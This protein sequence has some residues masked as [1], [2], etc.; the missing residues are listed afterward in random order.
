PPREGAAPRPR[1]PRPPR[2]GGEARRRAAP[3]GGAPPAVASLEE[4]HAEVPAEPQEDRGGRPAPPSA[5]RGPWARRH[6]ASGRRAVV[7]DVRR[8]PAPGPRMAPPGPG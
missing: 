1:R 5:A 6:R 3:N 7:R 2:G 4:V 8:D